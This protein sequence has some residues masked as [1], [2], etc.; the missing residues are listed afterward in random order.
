MVIRSFGSSPTSEDAGHPP[1]ATFGGL[2]VTDINISSTTS[3]TVMTPAH[4]AG[5]VDV[6]VTNS[7]GAADTVTNGFTYVAPTQLKK[8]NWIV[9]LTFL[10]GDFRIEADLVQDGNDLTGDFF[11]SSGGTNFQVN[12]DG[13][14]FG[15]SIDVTFTL[16]QGTAQEASFRCIGQL[17]SSSPQTFTGDFT[18]LSGSGTICG[19]VSPCEGTFEIR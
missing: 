2:P 3:F 11:Y 7:G 6:I 1:T 10:G 17:F 19:G 15:D 5:P 18:A 4:D 13:M 9:D 8:S 14:I 16:D 12:T